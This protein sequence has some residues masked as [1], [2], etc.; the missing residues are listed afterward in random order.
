MALADLKDDSNLYLGSINVVSAANGIIGTANNYISQ[1][2][3]LSAL[4]GYNANVSS[5]E[6]AYYQSV[7]DICTYINNNMPIPPDS[8]IDSIKME[9]D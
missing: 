5:E 2:I 1:I 4:P 7:T 3:N 8:L 6:A 9:N